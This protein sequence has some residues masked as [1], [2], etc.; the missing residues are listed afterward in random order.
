MAN[1]FTFQSS[2][3]VGSKCVSLF[4][5]FLRWTRQCRSS[6]HMFR[7]CYHFGVAT[8]LRRGGRIRRC[9]GAKFSLRAAE[10]A[11]SQPEK[12]TAIEESAAKL[13]K[14]QDEEDAS[15]KYRF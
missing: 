3:T 11:T 10:L 5:R 14:L 13:D 2:L 8:W 12:A 9:R 6:S 15:A 4:S 7:F 1:A